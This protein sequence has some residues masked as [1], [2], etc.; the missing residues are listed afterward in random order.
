LFDTYASASHPTSSCPRLVID[1]EFPPPPT[2]PP[3]A[4]VHVFADGEREGLDL[5]A[6][7]AAV[8]EADR[9]RDLAEQQRRQRERRGDREMERRGS[10]RSTFSASSAASDEMPTTPPPRARRWTFG[11]GNKPKEVQRHRPSVSLATTTMIM[12]PL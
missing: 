12:V 4:H 1:D 7:V 8:Q 6:A 9:Q 5:T 3:E 11:K 10:E 2:P